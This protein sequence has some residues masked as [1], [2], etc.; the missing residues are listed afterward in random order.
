V[1]ILS[2]SKYIFLQLFYFVTFLRRTPS[3][4]SLQRSLGFIRSLKAIPGF[5]VLARGASAA[6]VRSIAIIHPFIFRTS[7]TAGSIFLY[8]E[9]FT[10]ALR[11]EVS[12]P[13]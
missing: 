12:L 5:Q 9:E 8:Q 13:K 3:E 7:Q 6:R 11:P 1:S 10:E 2:P 4:R